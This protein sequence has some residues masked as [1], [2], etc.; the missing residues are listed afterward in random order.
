MLF[1]GQRPERGFKMTP[2]RLSLSELR[3]FRRC[4]RTWWLGYHQGFQLKMP[5]IVGARSLGNIVH[6]ALEA[7]YLPGTLRDMSVPLE[8]VELLRA[9]DLER[10]AVEDTF[11]DKLKKAHDQYDLARIMV[12]GY[13]E[14]VEETGHDAYLDVLGVEKNLEHVV[15]ARQG[16]PYTLAG[17]VDHLAQYSNTQEVIIRDY[18]T[19]ANLVDLPKTASLNE[20][21]LHYYW[22]L[23]KIEPEMQIDSSEFVMLRKVKRTAQAKPPFYGSHKTRINRFKLDAWSRRLWGMVNDVEDA[24]L[25]LAAGEDPMT[26]CYP[27]PL[28]TCSWD[29]DHLALCDMLDDGSRWE[30]AAAEF[31]AIGDPY[32]RYNAIT[33]EKELE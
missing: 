15:E 14:W 8:Q 30:E 4:R 18:K 7:Y 19:V 2:R 23:S 27:N 33:N 6:A 16:T 31:Y 22:L 5:E 11:G 25:R 13:V 24:E 9:R 10:L 32:A 21:G 20:Q 26:V 28:S 12:E 29:C 17:R 1:G 3:T